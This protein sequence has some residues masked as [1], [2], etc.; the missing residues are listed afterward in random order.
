L[1]E[2]RTDSHEISVVPSRRVR[3]LAFEKND[4]VDVAISLSLLYP[5]G[6]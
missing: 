6:M 1:T 5:A 3:H 2:M 4:V